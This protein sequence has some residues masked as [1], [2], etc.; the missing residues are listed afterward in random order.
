MSSSADDWRGFT[1][2]VLGA[3]LIA[4]PLLLLTSSL[5]G[6]G[7]YDGDDEARYLASIADNEALYYAAGMV[8]VL[9]AMAMVGAVLALI[10]LVRTR[11]P[12]YAKLAGGV[13]LLG[14]LTFAGVFLSFTIVDFELARAGDRDAM[15]AL[16]QDT[17]DSASSAPFFVTWI[18]TFLGLIL[19]AAGLL[20]SHAVP[21]WMPALLI[22]GLLLLFI[23]EAS[24]VGVVASAV[25]L[26]AMGAIGLAVLRSP[27]EAWETGDVA[28][29]EPPL[30]TA[31]PRAPAVA[32][33]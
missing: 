5:L 11:Y 8:G 30:S 16:L 28:G 23:S 19:L 26:V 22:V 2:T 32:A 6:T 14:V 25:T 29:G 7:I 10:H 4:A 3:C 18:G 17:E 31:P 27:V 20:R 24:W 33:H 21:R 12:R 9:G 1:K 15:V 13:A